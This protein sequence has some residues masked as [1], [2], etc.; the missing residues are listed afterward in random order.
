MRQ[1]SDFLGKHEGETAWIFGKG[2]SLSTF[3]FKTAGS[4]RFAI[5]D[6][7]AH[8][9][10]CA[11]GFAN[12]GVAKWSDAYEPHHILFQPSRCLHEYDSTKPGAVACEV[13]TFKDDSEDERL[14]YPPHKLAECLSIRRGTLGSALQIIRIMGIRELHLVGIDGGGQHAP[15]YIW[16]TRLRQDHA[17]DYDAIRSAAIDAAKI[18]GMTLKFHNQTHTMQNDG[19]VFVKMTKNCFAEA[20]PY[21]LGEIASFSPK[22][23]GELASNRCAEPY[24]PPAEKPIIESAVIETPETASMPRPQARKKA[25]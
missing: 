9:P 17:K 6:V 25:K 1:L 12:D 11:Y 14:T 5:N 23:A 3:D 8:I 20:K 10:D 13:V 16:R 24:S 18:M 15:G 2:P 19:R 7:I 4:I 21:Y 22:V